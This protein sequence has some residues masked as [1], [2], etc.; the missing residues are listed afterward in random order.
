MD[1]QGGIGASWGMGR[2]EQK[3]IKRKRL[4]DRRVRRF[5]SLGECVLIDGKGRLRSPFFCVLVSESE[6]V[7][8]LRIPRSGY[9]DKYLV[10][11]ALPEFTE[12]PPE[13]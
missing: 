8:P 4:S 11:L 9:L 1:A 12:E 13:H 2:G 3:G 10:Y 7:I 5:D 6:C